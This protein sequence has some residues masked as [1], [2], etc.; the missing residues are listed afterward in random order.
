LKRPAAGV[1]FAG[2]ILQATGSPTYIF[3][4][5]DVVV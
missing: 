1:F 5:F 4:V 2:L 3:I